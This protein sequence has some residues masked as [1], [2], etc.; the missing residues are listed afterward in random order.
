MGE[1]EAVPGSRQRAELAGELAGLAGVDV[2]VVDE[3]ADGF[4]HRRAG[5]ELRQVVGGGL[6]RLRVEAEAAEEDL[7]PQRPSDGIA[8]S[9][10]ETR[11][12]RRKG[13]RW[14]GGIDGAMEG[15]RVRFIGAA[16]SRSGRIGEMGI[17]LT[18]GRNPTDCD[19]G[20]VEASAA[21]DSDDGSLPDHRRSAAASEVYGIA[22]AT[23]VRAP[24][25][26]VAVS[27]ARDEVS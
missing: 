21:P 25:T 26:S 6:E 11:R 16:T 7:R 15:R 8:M 9:I 27:T 12:R 24:T 14:M 10:G 4:V 19:G 20:D 2:G 22:A 17:R 1:E 3:G 13:K 18:A 23:T 5:E